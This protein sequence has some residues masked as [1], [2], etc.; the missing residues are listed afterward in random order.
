MFSIPFQVWVHTIA[1]HVIDKVPLALRVLLVPE[2]LLDERRTVR[3]KP[4]PDEPQATLHHVQVFISFVGPSG[5]LSRQC[6][7]WAADSPEYLRGSFPAR[8]Y[9]SQ[10]RPPRMSIPTARTAALNLI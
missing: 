2:Q 5:P 10:V 7:L 9:S 3:Q 6:R 8:S 4:P 1:R